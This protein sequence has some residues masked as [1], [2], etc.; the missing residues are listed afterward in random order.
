MLLNYE[1]YSPNVT[2]LWG[3]QSFNYEAY[4]PNVDQLWGLQS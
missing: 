4:N 1:A 3:L 2:Q